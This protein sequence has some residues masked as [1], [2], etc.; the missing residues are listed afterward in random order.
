RPT[1]RRLAPPMSPR[2]RP[3]L[4]GTLLQ[5]EERTAPAN[6]RLTGVVL[7]DATNAPEANPVYGQ[8]TFVRAEW[9]SEAMAGTEPAVPVRY[10][11]NFPVNYFFPGSSAVSYRADSAAINL[12]TGSGSWST[13][14]GG[15]YA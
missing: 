3:S 13:Y 1:I 10:T 12:G 15:W 11:A 8:N 14:R 7:V 4:I 5:L 9:A 6:L 2:R